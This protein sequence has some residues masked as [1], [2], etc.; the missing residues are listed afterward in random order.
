MLDLFCGAGGCSVGYYRSGFTKIVGVDI[1]PQ[2]RYPFEFMQA[3]ALAT[4]QHLI[5][6]GRIRPDPM[7]DEPTY[8]LGDFDAIH[9]SP[10]CQA[11]TIAKSINGRRHPDL[12]PETRRLL[13][14][15]GKPWVIENV[16]G[17][18][19]PDAKVC[20]GLAL[21]LKVKRHRLFESSIE[22]WFPPCPSGH[23]GEW[24]TVFGNGGGTANRP[25]LATGA[26]ARK[27][28]NIGWMNRYELSQAIPPD[29]T[30]L[31]GDQLRAYVKRKA[32]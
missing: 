21:G 12:V 26:T 31:V 30:E 18:P 27:A 10:P 1:N 3:D 6:G 5:N 16:P 22:L 15:S 28:M 8:G 17:A 19:M 20:C 25:R 2:P 24:F 7:R 4:L 29:Y 32:A 11:Y 9:A 14:E 23:K 13:E